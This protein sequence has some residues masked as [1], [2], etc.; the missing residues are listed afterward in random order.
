MPTIM[1]APGRRRPRLAEVGDEVAENAPAEDGDAAHGRRAFLVLVLGPAVLLAEDGLTPAHAAEEPDREAGP[2]QRDQHGQ[3]AATKRGDEERDPRA[4]ASQLASSS[5]RA[6]ARSSKATTRS[7]TVCVVSWPLPAI[8]HDVAGAAASK[9]Q[10]DGRAAVGL[11]ERARAST[12]G[13]TGDHGVDDG[14][15]ILAARVVRRDDDHV[16]E[17]AGRRRPSPAAW[18]R[19]GRRH[20]RRPR[21]PRPAGGLA[22]RRR[23]PRPGPR[24][25]GRSRRP[26][27]SGWPASTGSNR[28]G[29]AG[30]GREPGGDRWRRRRRAPRPRSP[31]RARWPR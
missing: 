7:P 9:R 29:T 19:R 24:A 5:S 15:R 2:D 26:R 18:P 25:C 3:R 4:L 14:S 17:P 31:P 30:G 8:T 27:R 6:T 12:G 28:P 20:S 23:G 11:D 1:I 21:A 13:D 22:G 16:G 10:G